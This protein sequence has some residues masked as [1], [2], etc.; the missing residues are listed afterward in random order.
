VLFKA[1]DSIQN[2]HYSE[3]RVT[4]RDYQHVATNPREIRDKT[5]CGATKLQ[6]GHSKNLMRLVFAL[7]KISFACEFA[8]ISCFAADLCYSNLLWRVWD[9]QSWEVDNYMQSVVTD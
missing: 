6:E 5:S 3:L 9:C 2:K 4:I 1:L 8:R 7:R